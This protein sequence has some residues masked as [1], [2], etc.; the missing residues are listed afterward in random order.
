LIAR[1]DGFWCVTI[2]E[3]SISLALSSTGW[4][5]LASTIRHCSTPGVACN[6]GTRW[7]WER[8]L[9]KWV[10]CEG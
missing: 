6:S 8:A 7:Q 3:V 9:E 2:L 1:Q 10:W 4:G 5:Q